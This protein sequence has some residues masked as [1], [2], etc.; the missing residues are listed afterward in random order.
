MIVTLRGVGLTVGGVALLAT[1]FTF[2]YPELAVLGATAVIAQ[3]HA[4]IHAALRPRLSV[5][6]SVEP[7]RVARGEGSTVTLTV[8]NTGR[9]GAA[10]LVAHDQC[11][12]AGQ[13]ATVAVPLLRLRPGTDTDVSYPVPTDRRGV[14][15]VGPLQVTRRDPLGL[16]SVSRSHGDTARIW[17][18]PKSHLIQA[19]PAGIS[20][21]LDGRLDRVPHGAI[22]FDTLREYVIGDELR[23]VHW[24]TSAKVGELM[25]REHLDTSL[26]QLVVLLD[27]RAGS[28]A[29]RDTTGSAS[30]ESACEAAASIVAAATREDLPVT[31]HLVTGPA[32]GGGRIRGAARALLDLLAEA[33]PAPGGDELLVTATSRL[34]QHRPGDTLIY[35]TGTA[36][37]A[38][39]ALV[40]G[41]KGPFPSVAVG[42]LGPRLATEPQ[43]AGVLLLRAEDGEDFA[44]VWDGVA[45][46]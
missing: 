37:L 7:D 24:R 4:L 11:G 44:A 14:V 42:V 41:L 33:E 23:H 19:V 39:L 46:W 25:V 6:R 13:R 28:W 16:V 15:D 35:L 1:G 22:T 45:R 2:G 20:R 21:S 40:S 30:F 36:G 18:Y 31:L 12:R 32:A 17:V 26:P 29:D 9:F 38:D 3:L 5:T 8:R 27:D 10:T 43:P 34:R